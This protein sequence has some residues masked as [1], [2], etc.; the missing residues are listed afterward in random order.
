LVPAA[1]VVEPAVAAAGVALGV[2]WAWLRVAQPSRAARKSTV[3][4]T[5]RREVKKGIRAWP[6]RVLTLQKAR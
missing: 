1:S 6:G 5:K 4:I 2:V 3:F